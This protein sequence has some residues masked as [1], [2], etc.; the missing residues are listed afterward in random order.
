[1]PGFS[2]SDLTGFIA[3]LAVLAG[4]QFLGTLLVNIAGLP[5]PGAVAGL[6]ILLV[7]LA[8]TGYSPPWLNNTC[9]RLI[10]LLSLFF[11]P[12]AVGIFFLGEL[13]QQQYP[14]ILA[15]ILV[16]TPISIVLSALIM[17]FFIRRFGSDEP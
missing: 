16:A 11:L 12:A 4:F 17:Q 7:A 5:I 9:Y 10:S 2:F 1:M 15:A 13:F 3:G 6:M 8:V 14:A